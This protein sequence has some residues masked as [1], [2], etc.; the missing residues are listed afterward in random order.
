MKES[1]PSSRAA[2]LRSTLEQLEPRVAP[3]AVFTYTD[4]D[5]DQVTIK[6]NE[7]TNVALES[8][9]GFVA[10]PGP[11]S[12]AIRINEITLAGLP[13]F[14]GTNIT[15]TASPGPQGGDGLVNIGSINATDLDLGKVSIDGGLGNLDAG[16]TGQ[17]IQRITIESTTGSGSW[18]LAGSVGKLIVKGDI[19]GTEIHIDDGDA[20]LGLL[21]VG[22]SIIGEN[23]DVSGYVGVNSGVLEKAVVKGDIRGAANT[24]GGMIFADAILSATINGDVVG[25]SESGTGVIRANIELGKVTIKGSVI[26]GGGP[27]SGSI[28]SGSLVETVS[29][30]GSLIGGSATDSG[31]IESGGEIGRVK[32]TGDIRG[33]TEINSGMISATGGAIAGVTVGGSVIGGQANTTGRIAAEGNVG[34]VKIGGDLISIAHGAAPGLLIDSGNIVAQLGTPLDAERANITSITIG[35]S[36]IGGSDNFGMQITSDGAIGPVK[37]GGDLQGGEGTGS[38]SI[39]G[40]TG[41]ASLNIGGSVAGYSGPGSG[42]IY[43][44]LGEIGNVKIGRSLTGGSGLI[45][46]RLY[47]DQRIGNVTIG[48]DVVAGAGAQTGEVYCNA[49][50]MGALKVSGSLI[51][52]DTHLVTIH[53]AP[54]EVTNLTAI[55]SITIGGNVDH[56]RILASLDPDVRVGG[57]QVGGSWIASNLAAGVLSGAD[58][59]YGTADDAPIPS[60]GEP[61]SLFSRIASITITGHVI[62]TSALGDHF[63]FV[64][65]QIG[66]MKVNGVTI[67][68]TPGHTNDTDVADTQLILGITR[69]VTVHEVA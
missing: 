46:G 50:S 4:V 36:V 62:G 40:I 39:H 35:G 55:K 57:V 60:M 14:D 26:G 19:R 54:G 44:N 58:G 29:I 37:I 30:G 1:L 45:S 3:A 51:G 49:G 25:G 63:G 20:T 61:D 59:M 33:G 65:Q 66:S 18:A 53:A 10:I 31:V 7:G 34:P 16:V 68:L 9:I 32:V 64:A 42:S 41:I 24:Q 48:G 23:E 8:A 6:T 22:G 2:V 27:V 11:I 43:S 38:G 12:G 52:N 56:T 5:G 21:K 15:V 69:D 47:A 17:L 13:G 28:V 67:P